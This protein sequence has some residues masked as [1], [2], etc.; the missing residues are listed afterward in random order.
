ME[1]NTELKINDKK[2]SI[3]ITKPFVELQNVSKYYKKNAALKNINFKVGFGE[4]IGIIGANGGGKST[5]SEIIGGIRQPSKGKVITQDNLTIGIQFQESK[6]PIG[7]TVIDMI[8]YYLQTFKIEMSA[9]KLQELLNTYQLIGFENK[10]IE[11]LSGGQQQRLNILLAIIH[12]PDLVILDEVSTGLDIEVKAEIFDFL[13]DNIVKLNKAM[14]LVTHNMSEIEEFCEKYIYIHNGEI[15]ETGMVADLVKKYGSVHEYTWKMFEKNKK[16]DLERQYKEAQEKEADLKNSSK[17]KIDRIIHNGKS[18]GK[19]RPLINLMMKYYYKG[20]AVPF[21]MFVFPIIILFLQGFAFESQGAVGV[22]TIIGSIAMV[23]A[24]SV[25]IFVIPQTIVEFKTS[26]LMKRIGAT[27]IKPITFVI[28][29]MLV[30]LLFIIIAFLWTMLWGG[31]MFGTQFGWSN[32]ALPKNILASIPFILIVF[33]S[34]IAIGMAIA[35]VCKSMTS[36]IAISNIIYMPI[37]FL[38]G[39]FLPVELIN[40]SDVLKYIT[41]INPFKYAL[42]PFLHAWKGGFTMKMEYY[43][44]IPV[45]IAFLGAY[46]GLAS[47]KM[48]WQS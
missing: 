40:N 29:V 38:S 17:N 18:Q 12:N 14:L 39:A 19:N 41:Y 3:D 34:S 8:K 23:Q 6:Y 1:K 9:T 21:F 47:W 46:V 16:S 32:V 42:E 43:I 35:S 11:S 22:H 25:G 26:V 2:P 5:M 27:N 28:S 10:F 7:I 36:L 13:R 44:Y 37:A 31:I 20:V 48:R 15:L 33:A 30:G 24:M 4:R 45:S